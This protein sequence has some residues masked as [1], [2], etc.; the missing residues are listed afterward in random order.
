MDLDTVADEL[1]AANS[2]DFIALRKAAVAAARADGDKELAAD[3]GKLRK[4]TAV[5]WALNVLA[6]ECPD[7]VGALLDVGD[8]LREAQR[9]LSAESLRAFDKQRQ[10]VIAGLTKRTAQLAIDRGQPLG[11]NAIREVGQ[12]LGAAMADPETG[13]LLRIGRVISAVQHSGFGSS[14]DDVFGRAG[15]RVITGGKAVKPADD[16]AARRAKVADAREALARAT[17]DHDRAATAVEELAHRYDE[18]HARIDEL[19]AELS[20]AESELQVTRRG[21]DAAQKRRGHAERAVA[22]AQA[23]VDELGEP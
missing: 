22:S 19:R 3:I 6:R 20:E 18:L 14:A 7:D 12:T 13:E 15:L 5:G 11:D 17:D 16:G 4:P 2:T 23:K 10:Q 8:A 9:T 21:R 1:Y